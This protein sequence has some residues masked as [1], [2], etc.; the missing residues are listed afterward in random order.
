M[1]NL[2]LTADADTVVGGAADDTVYATAATLN[3]GDSLTGGAGTDVL[4][5]IGSGTFRVDQ[6]ASFTGFERI[7]LDNATNSFAYLSLGSQPIEVDATGYVY[8]QASSPS[9]WNGSDIINGDASHST[10]IIFSNDQGV[11]PPLPVT[12]DLTSNTLSHVNVSGSADNITLLINNAD[13]AGV[14]SFYTFGLGD[15]LAVLLPGA[16]RGRKCAG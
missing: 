8:I 13:T 5:L 2:S 1:A 10:N 16:R 3:A 4:A 11:Y 15:K 14:Q 12:Y 7:T 6:L 9:N